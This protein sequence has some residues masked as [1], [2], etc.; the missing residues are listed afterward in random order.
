MNMLATRFSGVDLSA[1]PSSPPPPSD[2]GQP[3]I[4]SV[5]NPGIWDPN[6]PVRF[7]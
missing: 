5:T 7:G 3:G 6:T 4:H 1:K 2:Y